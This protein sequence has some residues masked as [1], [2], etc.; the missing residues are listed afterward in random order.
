MCIDFLIIQLLFILSKQYFL[1]IHNPFL[2]LKLKFKIIFHNF[3]F[4]LYINLYLNKLYKF[5]CINKLILILL[6]QLK[7]FHIIIHLFQVIIYL[8]IF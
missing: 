1:Q 3:I 5:H 2:I 4:N 6:F 7:I 8:I